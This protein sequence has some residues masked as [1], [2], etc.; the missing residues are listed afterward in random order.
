VAQ[1]QYLSSSRLFQG[2]YADVA[3]VVLG[4][5]S[6]LCIR[7]VV[8]GAVMWRERS[9]LAEYHATGTILQFRRL[10]GGR[11]FYLSVDG[12]AVSSRAFKLR[13]DV[14]SPGARFSKQP[15]SNK[16]WV[17]GKEYLLY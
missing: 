5:A 8:Q 15:G 16:C 9:V 3:V 1:A 11:S 12:A 17:D 7:P 13:D 6:T 10:D 4:I 2:W 14:L